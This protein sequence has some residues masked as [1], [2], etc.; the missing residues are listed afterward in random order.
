MRS[1]IKSITRQ[2]KK[3]PAFTVAP[4]YNLFYQTRTK[5]LGLNGI[6][7]AR[8]VSTQSSTMGN[9]SSLIIQANP[10]LVSSLQFFFKNYLVYLGPTEYMNDKISA[11]NHC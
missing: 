9:N 5:I 10:T 11:P 8:M 2:T 6:V 3:N 1:L 4:G 7:P